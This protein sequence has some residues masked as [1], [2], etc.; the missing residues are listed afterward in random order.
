VTLRQVAL[1]AGVHVS[2][3][4]RALDPQRRHLIGSDIV[5]K[6][7]ASARKLGYRPNRAAAAL[8][9]GRSFTIG[10]LLPDITNPV[11][12]PILRGIEAALAEPGYV[13]LVLNAPAQG[14][15]SGA[16]GV[17]ASRA[18]AERLLAQGVDG[19]ILA[20]ASD[21]DPALAVLRRAHLG[22]GLPVVLVNRALASGEVA[23]VVSDDELGMAL[24]VEHLAGLGHTRIAHLAG[25]QSLSTGVGRLRGLQAALAAR[26]L[27]G[28]QV[29]VCSAYSREAG[30][31]GTEAL[32]ATRGANANGFTAIVAANDLLALG[33]YD[34]LAAAGLR[35]PQDVSVVGH[36]DMPLVDLIAP[37]L[38]TIRIQHFEMGFQ[39]AKQLL[40]QLAGEPVGPA[41]VVL[42]P[43]L[44]VR[45]STVRV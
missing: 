7:E 36:N 33:A 43:A 45:G 10:V 13:P 41:K 20:T 15:A 8:R 40:A 31:V 44:V 6:V 5:D 37:P 17:S 4:S 35:V 42:R 21:D 30:R 24:A 11:F 29:A 26:G 9:T 2:T 16:A 23:A 34:A 1:A 12:P 27:P 3:V 19:A 14:N 18:V 32:L 38:T 25:P 22:A 39:A 28:A